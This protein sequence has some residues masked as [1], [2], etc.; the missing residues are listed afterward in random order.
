MKCKNTCF[1]FSLLL[2][3]IHQVSFAQ[4]IPFV[5]PVYNYNTS[6][7]NGGNQNWAVAQDKNGIIYVANN[8]G[9]LSF[10]GVNWQLHTLPNNIGVKS[11]FIDSCQTDNGVAEKIYVGA[12]EDFGYFERDATNRLI[13]HS[14]KHLA[15]DYTFKNDEIWTIVKHDN[16]VYFQSFSSYFSYTE[17]E[18]ISHTSRPSPRCFFNLNNEVYVSLISD[19]LFLL[20]DKKF[21]RIVSRDDLDDDDIVG[22]ISLKNDI[23]LVTSKNG[24]YK[25]NDDDNSVVKWKTSVDGE[26]KSA[27][28]NRAVGVSD[29]LFVVGSISNGVYAINKNGELEWQLNRKIGLNNNTILGLY[30]DKSGNLWAALDNGVSNI[31]LNSDISIFE[32]TDIQIGMVEDILI[33]ENES[34]LASNQGIYQ[35]N[36]DIKS[37]NQLPG[38]DI[39]TWYIKKIDDQIIAGHN[40]GASFIENNKEVPL[41][42]VSIGGTNIKEITVNGNN[43]LIETTYSFLS[44]FLKDKSG[45]WNFSHNITDG[46]VDL[47]TDIEV[48]HTGNIWLGHMYKGV[49]RLRLDNEFKKVVEKEYFE[50][51]DSLRT[52]SHLNV[53]KLR[54]RVVLSDGDS[55]YTYDDISQKVIPFSEL[56][57]QLKEHAETYRIKPINDNL[58]WFIKNK[59]YVLIEYVKGTYKIKDKVPFTILNNPP[60]QGRANIYVDKDDVSYFCLNGGVGKYLYTEKKEETKELLLMNAW[61]FNRDENENRY[62]SLKN[63]NTIEFNENTLSLNFAYPDFSKRTFRVESFLENYDTRWMPTDNKLSITYSNLPADNYVLKARILNDLGEEISQLSFPFKIKNPWYMSNWAYFLYIIAALLIAVSLTITYIRYAINRNNKIFEAQENERIAQLN[64]QEKQI[65]TL[66]SERLEADLSHKSKELANATMLIINHEDFLKDLK[67]DIQQNSLTGKIQKRQGEMLINKIE[68]NLSDEDE[69]AL[70]QENF[71]LIHKNFF[72]NLKTAYPDLTPVDL[73]LCALLRLNYSTKEIAKM[74]NLSIRGVEAARY[75]LRKK[76]DIEENEDLVSF[77]ISF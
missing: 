51:L 15:K 76:I 73:R 50:S 11:I 52:A 55:F 25:Y 12:F 30:K 38:S 10:D 54:G 68:Q 14:L 53:M 33:T 28:I 43:A 4:D 2:L 22:M 20:K 71:D 23:L 37:F 31:Q 56:N 48:D 74:Q 67:K 58:F 19:G 60:N 42:G 47:V 46:F 77:M 61:T 69:W 35:Y 16:T 27:V 63:H 64:E 45:K 36:H 3:L 8:R 17:N 32:P 66:K 59:E 13:Y 70:F 9:L 72:R 39:Q 7:N 18:V 41:K 57:R 5:P 49:Y 29:S 44:V 6:N 75:R 62:L 1:I 24:I 65:A 34:Y 40:Q 21:N 26:L